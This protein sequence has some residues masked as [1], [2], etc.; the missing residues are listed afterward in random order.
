MA[1][2]EDE[3]AP[4]KTIPTSDLIANFAA[5]SYVARQRSEDLVARLDGRV[6]TQE[7]LGRYLELLAAEIDARIPPRG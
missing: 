3:D 1:I 7:Q 5:A 2:V 4:L 6:L